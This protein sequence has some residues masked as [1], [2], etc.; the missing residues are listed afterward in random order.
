MAARLNVSKRSTLV[1]K[2]I[3]YVYAFIAVLVAGGLLP[4]EYASI[5]ALLSWVFIIWT[6]VALVRYFK[7]GNLLKKRNEQLSQLI[8]QQAQ[9][10]AGFDLSPTIDDARKRDRGLD[11]V[12]K[13]T[14]WAF[15]DFRYS[16]YRKTRRGEYKTSTHYRAV[17]VFDLPRILPNVF[18]DAKA[19]KGSEFKMLFDQEQRHSLEGNFDEF[20]ETYFSKEYAIDSLSFIT[21]EV[22]QAM[23]AAKEYDIEIYKDKLYLYNELENMPDQLQTVERLGN[24]VRTTLLNNIVTYRDDRLSYEDGRQTVS[25]QAIQLRRSI[26]KEV[27]TIILSLIAVAAVSV[28]AAVDGFG[29]FHLY[30]VIGGLF[31]A[32]GAYSSIRRIRSKNKKIDTKSRTAFKEE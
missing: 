18:F 6:I 5:A 26:F 23:I 24:K 1:G 25:V 16:V 12:Y 14:D 15:G 30:G 32:F 10:G 20:F 11:N 28:H 19:T 22:M 17:A 29:D 31:V 21:P 2:F 8:S 13:G 9:T 3:F 4:E 27:V 7:Q